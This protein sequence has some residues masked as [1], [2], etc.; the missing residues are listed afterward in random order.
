MSPC[1]VT[2]LI[3]TW[4]VVGDGAH[5]AGGVPMPFPLP[6]N[7]SFGVCGGNVSPELPGCGRALILASSR[8]GAFDG[9]NLYVRRPIP[10]P[11]P[12]AA[13]GVLSAVEVC[14]TSTSETLGPDT[15]E[16]YALSIPADDVTVARVRANTVYGAMHALE[17]LTQL[18]DV[19]VGKGGV[20]SIPVA[21]VNVSDA[22]QYPY[23]GLMID[24][25]RH[26]LPLAHI[27]HVIEAASMVKLSVLHI[28]FTDA[29]SFPT[30][31]ALYPSLCTAGAYPNTYSTST[32]NTES[33]ARNVSKAAT[34]YTL[35]ELRDL[36]AFA[37]SHGIRIQPEW[38]MPGHGAWAY[39]MPELTTS[40]CPIVLDPTQP[41]V[42]SFMRQFLQEMGTVFSDSYLFLGGDEVDLT[43]FSR[44]PSIAAWMKARGVNASAV[45]RF[46]WQQMSSQVFPHLNNRTISL[47]R[48]D[49]PDR[50]A[51][52][53]DV[54]ANTVFNVYQSLSTAWHQTVPAAVPTV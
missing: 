51:H 24:T 6:V 28:H 30:C 3:I 43:C 26:F 10:Q 15:D 4:L 50:G 9:D 1:G 40:A 49:D 11:K 32:A 27:R 48:A 53:S 21:P 23:R 44:S 7:F 38:D 37:K 12:G 42:Y 20:L 54:P 36:V 16:S 31:S 13:P 52:A 45:Q 8:S 5:V 2:I 22:P 41:K 47:W 29:Q 19:R 35:D 33:P 14:L 46:F 17:S 18:V 34:S 25:A 39:G